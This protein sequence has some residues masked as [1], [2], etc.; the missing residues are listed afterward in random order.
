MRKNRNE[1]IYIFFYKCAYQNQKLK[2]SIDYYVMNNKELSMSIILN[3][4]SE[5]KF[6]NSV[7]V[8]RVPFLISFISNKNF[9]FRFTSAKFLLTYQ[10]CQG[11]TFFSIQIC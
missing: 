3:K 5:A 2:F 9:L 10:C 7:A 4:I 1:L 11:A 6:P 8:F